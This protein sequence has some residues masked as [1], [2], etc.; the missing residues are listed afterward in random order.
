MGCDVSS[1]KEITKKKENIKR[2]KIHSLPIKIPANKPLTTIL[3]NQ[4]ILQ[5]LMQKPLFV[6]YFS[7]LTKYRKITNDFELRFKGLYKEI[8]KDF[9]KLMNRFEISI[10]IPDK[11]FEVDLRSFKLICS[12]S[13]EEDLDCY[14]PLFLFEILIYP[15]SFIKILKM[16]SFV[17]INSLNFVTSEYQQYRAACP[18]YY[19]TLSMYYCTKERTPSYIRTVIHHELFHYVDII[20][21]K[22]YE[23]PKFSKFNQNG[24]KYG[25]GGAYE[26]EWK[27]LDPD[28]QGFL[29][30]YSTTGIEEDKAEIFQNL[31]S[32]PELGF[33]HKDRIIN[34]KTYYIANFLK[35]FDKNGIG[36]KENDFFSALIIFRNKYFY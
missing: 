24:F 23:D 9:K 33:K 10:E 14:L 31:M 26:R 18:E 28:S 21:D 3:E 11:E 22:T 5:N 4:D 16:K 8:E 17:F 12:P 7:E 1:I 30:F 25:R 19:K 29:N 20:D 32:N 13:T 2:E 36:N 15:K 27:P 34:N 35:D 6:E